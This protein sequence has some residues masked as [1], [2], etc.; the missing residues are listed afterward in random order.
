MEPAAAWE[1]VVL[2]LYEYAYGTGDSNDVCDACD[3]IVRAGRDLRSADRR[4]PPWGC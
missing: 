3:A 2:Q 1:G 4:P